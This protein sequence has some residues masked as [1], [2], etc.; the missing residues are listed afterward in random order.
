MSN[1]TN[2]IQKIE[3]LE[4]KVKLMISERLQ[5]QTELKSMQLEVT[6]LQTAMLEKND[7]IKNFQNQHKIT[8]IANVVSDTTK[9]NVELRMLLNDYI[10]EIDKCIAHLSE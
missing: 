3:S 8:K 5:L 7:D 9:S 2:I 1:D 4:Y 6:K 10:R